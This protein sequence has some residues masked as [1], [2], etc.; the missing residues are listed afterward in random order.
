M[1]AMSWQ[2][3]EWWTLTGPTISSAQ[4]KGQ[5]AVLLFWNPLCGFCS[6]MLSDLKEWEDQHLEHLSSLLV[7]SAGTP[8]ANRA[9]EVEVK[10]SPRSALQHRNV[11]WRPRNSICAAPRRR[12]RDC[13]A[14]CGR[15]TR[16]V[17]RAGRDLR[18]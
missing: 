9:M 2:P 6:S 8:E 13:I 10:G 18:G 5:E 14:D 1:W 11:T 7:V 17:G 12:R 16:S 15:A 4:I 3:S